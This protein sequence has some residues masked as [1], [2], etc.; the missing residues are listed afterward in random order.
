MV[1]NGWLNLTFKTFTIFK[2]PHIEPILER[3]DGGTV[4]DC[5]T[6]NKPSAQ[7]MK[8]VY[9]HKYGSILYFLGIFFTFLFALKKK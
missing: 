5:F 2:F 4:L 8:T 9:V 1:F 6:R 7:L 3:G